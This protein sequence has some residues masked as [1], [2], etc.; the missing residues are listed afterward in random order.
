MGNWNPQPGG[1]GQQPG[2][3]G[4][5]GYGGGQPGGYGAPQPG[6]GSPQPGGYGQPTQPAAGYGQQQYGGGQPG[7]GAVPPPAQKSRTGCIVGGILGGIVLVVVV[8]AVIGVVLA[9]S[10]GKAY[11]LADPLPPAAGGLTKVDNPGS[12]Y[13]S[14]ANGAKSSFS[15]DDFGGTASATFSSIYKDGSGNKLIFVGANGSFKDPDSLKNKLSEGASSG[16]DKGFTW[17]KVD[18]GSHGGI[19]V[20]AEGTASSFKASFCV[21]ETKGDVGELMSFGFPTDAGGSN[22][23]PL[24]ATQLADITR[25][26][27]AS[28]ESPK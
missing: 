20:C 5:P 23:T 17:D 2:G 26:F 18:A 24:T 27:R 14:A 9:S 28:A 21:F 12:I 15:G 7:F 25:S 11:S 10:G 8:I 1:Y 6:Y 3:Y 22:S 13:S 4:Q 19:M 16:S